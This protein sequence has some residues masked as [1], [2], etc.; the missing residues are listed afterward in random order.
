MHHNE[1][2]IHLLQLEKGCTQQR[3]FKTTKDKQIIYKKE[4]L[5]SPLKLTTSYFGALSPS[6][7]AHILGSV[8]LSKQIQFLPVTLSLSEFFLQ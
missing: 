2:S 7:M 6:D 8:F 4:K 5:S 1:E 3:R